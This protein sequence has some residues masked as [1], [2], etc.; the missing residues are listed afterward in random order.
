[1]M[2][3]GQKVRGCN[4]YPHSSV[5]A[6]PVSNNSTSLVRLLVKVLEMRYH[7]LPSGGQKIK[8]F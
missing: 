3:R 6:V 5:T 7:L 4:I 1:M 8:A 2:Q